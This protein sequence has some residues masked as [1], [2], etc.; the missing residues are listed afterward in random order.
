MNLAIN[1]RDAM[2][3]GGCLTISTREVTVGEGSETFY[4]L[5]SPGRYVLVTVADTGTG[6]D[7][8]S[9][10]KIFDPF[11]T[12]KEVGKG[13]GLGLSIVYGIIKQHDGSIL[14]KSEPGE[15]TTFD[16]YLP[17]IQG[18]VRSEKKRKKRAY[19]R[20]QGDPADRRG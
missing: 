4:D 19:G 20:R 7:R 14:V 18:G 2:P 16:I 15:G 10:E 9:M 5:S 17:L 1:S 8:S 3:H 12:T 6:I 11:F 13:T